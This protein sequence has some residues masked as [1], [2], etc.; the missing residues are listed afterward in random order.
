MAKFKKIVVPKDGQK[1]TVR[2][3]KLIVPDNPII[4]FIEG[5]RTRKK[6]KRDQK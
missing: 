5:C 6:S 2:D 4:A 1:I 3:G